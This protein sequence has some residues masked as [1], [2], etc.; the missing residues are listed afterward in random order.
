MLHISGLTN[1]EG[2][3]GLTPISTTLTMETAGIQMRKGFE[4]KKILSDKLVSAY[5]E[6]TRITFLYYNKLIL[7]KVYFRILFKKA[8]EA[9]KKLVILG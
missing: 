9:G 7:K 2:W 8:L 4:K 6:L 5:W 3:W 1:M